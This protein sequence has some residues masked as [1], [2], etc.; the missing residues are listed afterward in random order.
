MSK[1]ATI[2]QQQLIVTHLF[3]KQEINLQ[4]QQ[5]GSLEIDTLSQGI[6]GNKPTHLL[7]QVLILPEQTIQ[8]FSLQ[9][10]NLRE[11]IIVSGEYNIHNL[12][13]GTTIQIGPVKIYLTYHCEPC[14][15]IAQYVSQAKLQHKRG[16]LGQFLSTGK[17]T[18]GDEVSIIEEK[19]EPIPH[20]LKDRI[21]W[22]LNKQT[23][24]VTIK[25]LVIGIGLSGSYCRAIPNIVRHMPL[26]YKLKISN[27]SVKLLT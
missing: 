8:G 5:V 17:I 16:Y 21:I 11:N 25:E 14:K 27:L 15:K 20:D 3:K 13:S 18:I 12:P 4:M 6:Q 7:R 1:E 23:D 10:G 9:P 2:I 19:Q 24:Q 26:K 22:F